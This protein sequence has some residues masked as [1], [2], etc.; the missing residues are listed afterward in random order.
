MLDMLQFL[1][2]DEHE[3]ISVDMIRAVS[4]SHLEQSELVAVLPHSE[5]SVGTHDEIARAGEIVTPVISY[6]KYLKHRRMPDQY[7]TLEEYCLLHGGAHAGP[8]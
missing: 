5:N 6:E 3:H 1:L 4:M 8:A 7:G 2:L